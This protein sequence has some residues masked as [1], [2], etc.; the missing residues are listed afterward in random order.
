MMVGQHFVGTGAWAAPWWYV[1][2]TFLTASLL[3]LAPP[4]TANGRRYTG[5]EGSGSV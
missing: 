5:V 4:L 3:I 2:T 1:L